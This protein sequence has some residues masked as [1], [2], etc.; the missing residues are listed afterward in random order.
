MQRE[1]VLI[2]V[3]TYPVLSTKYIELVCTAGV[4]E[5]GSWVRIYP[6]PFRFLEQDKQYSKYHWIEIDLEKNPKDGRPESF[7]PVNIDNIN[8]LNKV[9]TDNAWE[10]RRRLVLDN[11]KI[12]T[13]L[14]SI[15]EGARENR[16]SLVTFKPKQVLDLKVEKSGRDWE[17]TRKEAVKAA[18]TQGQLFDDNDRSDFALMPKLPYKFSYRFLDDEGKES[19]L[20]IEDWEIGQLYWKCRKGADEKTAIEKVRQMYID[21]IARTK[22]LYLFLGTTYEGHVR[23]FTNP[24]VI[25]GAFY[26]PYVYQPGLF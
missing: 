3:K 21:D 25:V 4:R 2:T 19:I 9:D 23:K 22:D 17:R 20:M 13:N 8:V 1:R 10:G 12:F 5:D 14:K 26:P 18:L 16:F 7:R 6:S 24:F 11:S 15:I